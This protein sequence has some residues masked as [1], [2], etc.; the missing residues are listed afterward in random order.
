[1]KRPYDLVALLEQE[2]RVDLLDS[3][4]DEMSDQRW[5]AVERRHTEIDKTVGGLLGSNTNEGGMTLEKRYFQ[6]DVD[7][8]AA[9]KPLAEFDLF[10]STLIQP[11]K[12]ML[13]SINPPI[14]KDEFVDYDDAYDEPFCAKVKITCKLNIGDIDKLKV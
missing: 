9:G 4:K 10:V 11:D 12:S 5:D 14:L 13:S 6:T 8:V 3:M 7:C 1:M 2:S